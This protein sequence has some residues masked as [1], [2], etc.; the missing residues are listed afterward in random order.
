MNFGRYELLTVS[1]IIG[2]NKH[3]YLIWVYYNMSNID[4]FDDVLEMLGISEENKIIKPG[5]DL[6]YKDRNL[7]LK[8]DF[9][10]EQYNKEYLKYRAI[11]KSRANGLHEM[12][13][14]KMSKKYNTRNW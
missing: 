10:Q 13:K 9:S 5:T 14:S 2:L 3:S 11:K 12:R 1:Q 4:F 7:K 6:N 8:K